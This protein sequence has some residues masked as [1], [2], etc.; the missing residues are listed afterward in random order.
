MADQ[1][2]VNQKTYENWEQGKYE[3]ED[4]FFPAVIRFMGYDPSPAPVSLPDR[5]RAARRRQG[6]SQ[7]ELAHCLGLDPSTVGTWEAG[8]VV[9]PFP[10]IAAL[11]E[12][13]VAGV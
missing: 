9:R 10:R 6:I 7:E 8:T 1:L 2:G 12:Q 5:I 4:R 3:P 11:F 13:Y